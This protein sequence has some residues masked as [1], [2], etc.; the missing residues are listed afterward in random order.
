MAISYLSTSYESNPY[1]IPVDLNMLQKVNSYKQTLFYKNAENI[2]QQLSDLNN[3][4]I[5]NE[6]Q[7][8]Y[9]KDKVNNLVTQINNVGGIDY[10]DMNISNQIEGFGSDIYNDDIVLSGI[11]STKSIR[12]FYKNKEKLATDPKLNKYYN[13]SNIARIEEEHIKPYINGDLNASY[14]GPTAPRPYENPME[15]MLKAMK[16]LPPDITVTATANGPALYNVKT[17]KFLSDEDISAAFDGLLDSNTKAQLMDD[18]WY[19][20][21]YSTG[22]KFDEKLG[23][24]LYNDDLLNKKNNYT[25]ALEAIDISLKTEIDPTTRKLYEDRKGDIQKELS[26]LDNQIST[27]NKAFSNMWNKDKDAAK[28]NL[29]V[30]R[31]RNDVIKAAGYSQEKNDYVKNEEYAWQKRKELAYIQHGLILNSDGTTTPI[32]GAGKGDGK[33]DFLSGF[34]VPG[35]SFRTDEELKALQVN[36]STINDEI[37]K[38]KISNNID[39]KDIIKDFVQLNGWENTMGYT[40]TINRSGVGSAQDMSSDLIVKITG[41]DNYLDR[42]DLSDVI[43]QATQQGYTGEGKKEFK[44]KHDGREF[45]MTTEQVKILS[46]LNDTWKNYASGKIDDIPDSF[47]KADFFPNFIKFVQTYQQ[48]ELNVAAKKQYLDNVLSSAFGKTGISKQDQELYR[49]WVYEGKPGEADVTESYYGRKTANPV[50]S[51]YYRMTS[52]AGVSELPRIEPTALGKRIEDLNDKLSKPVKE[53]FDTASKNINFYEYMLSDKK[54]PDGL[55]NRIS[56]DR[57]NNKENA[58]ASKIKPLSIIRAEDGENYKVFYSYDGKAKES[59]T[60]SPSEAS[61]FNLKLPSNMLLENYFKFG[62]T[63]SPELFLIPNTSQRIKPVLYIIKKQKEGT[64]IPYVNVNG[65]YEPVALP[66]RATSASDAEEYLHMLA[67]SVMYPSQEEFLNRA[68]NPTI[69]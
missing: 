28:Y 16:N 68:T 37:S 59:I 48:R 12:E 31:F 8:N 47:K 25:S 32:P 65:K 53:A 18:A 46:Q 54:I 35:S 30:S 63:Q 40:K 21:D 44:V 9:L 60:I 4:D 17:N 41:V 29:Y 27:G 1:I 43:K 7:H 49:Q 66:L 67:T 38:L 11:T 2:K 62:E 22:Y 69:Y 3:S 15:K 13:T 52:T 26:S 39:A 5:L 6:K 64:F 36:E 19:N 50:A 10:S 14:T 34:Y 33:G 23:Q 20:F 45:G 55:I 24:D 61:N 42:N 58:D 51:K 56:D 57:W